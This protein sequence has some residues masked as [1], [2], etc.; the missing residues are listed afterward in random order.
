MSDELKMSVSPICTKDGKKYAFVSF[1]DGIRTAEGKIPDCRI[2]ACDGFDSDEV[3]Q[4]EDYMSRELPQLKKMAAGIN[5]L[6]NFM[7]D[8]KT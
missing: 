2:T 5:I 4:L 7:D 3:M 6:K 8:A 1:T